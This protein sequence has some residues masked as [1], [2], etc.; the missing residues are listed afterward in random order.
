MVGPTRRAVL[1]GAPAALGFLAGCDSLTDPDGTTTR[2][3]RREGADDTSAAPGRTLELRN[4]T[5]VDQFVSVAV[6]RDER[7]VA[8]QTVEVDRGAEKAVEVRAATGILDVELETTTGRVAS[9]EWVVGDTIG[10]L[11]VTLTPAGVGFSQTAWCAPD[12][13]PLSR[14]GTASDFPSHGGPVFTTPVYG[15]NVLVENTTDRTLAI[16]L[17]IARDDES[18]LDYAYVVP[19]D[20]TL[21]FPAVQPEGDYTVH[22]EGPTGT[23]TTDWRPAMEH[24]LTVR[25]TADGVTATCG[26]V[27]ASF[28]L[29]NR[30]DVPHRVDVHAFRTGTDR[31]VLRRTYIVQP[32]ANYREQDVF[33]GSGQYTL[34]V[35]TAEGERASVDWW[36]CPPRGPTQV[37]VD[38]DGDLRVVQHDPDT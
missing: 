37:S 25:L 8:S 23:L 5:D 21:A 34:V 11:L 7:V 16:D 24:R 6:S 13:P 10:H 2:T 28:V 17:Q 35:R 30:D 4:E 20:V 32:G 12:C 18:L 3:T 9:H 1:R 15:A 14:G 38:A 31:A 26:T 36:L 33:T 27:T 29:S 19:P 22:V